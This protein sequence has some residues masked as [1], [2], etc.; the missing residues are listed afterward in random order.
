[1][2]EGIIAGCTI[3]HPLRSSLNKNLKERFNVSFVCYGKEDK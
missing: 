2:L 1:M 3:L